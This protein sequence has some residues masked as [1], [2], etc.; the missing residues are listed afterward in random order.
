M[1]DV[2]RGLGEH[3]LGTVARLAGKILVPY[4]RPEAEAASVRS[5]VASEVSA[6]MS[7]RWVGRRMTIDEERDEALAPGEE[8]RLVTR[9]AEQRER[10]VERLGA[11]IGEGRRLHSRLAAETIGP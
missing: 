11:G 4:E 6:S 2:P 9:L 8:L 3:A 5:R 1:P 10:V 7:T